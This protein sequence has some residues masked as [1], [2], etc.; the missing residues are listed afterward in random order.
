MTINGMQFTS[1]KSAIEYLWQLQD[2]D[3]RKLRR[4]AEDAIRKDKTK[5][6]QIIA[7]ALGG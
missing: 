3:Y 2:G 6:C 7:L 4:K 5:A 1:I